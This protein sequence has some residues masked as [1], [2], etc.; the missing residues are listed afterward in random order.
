M[1]VII[2][3]RDRELLEPLIDKLTEHGFEVMA[4][5]NSSAVLSY[6]KQNSIQF[7]LADSTLLM[8]HTLAREVLNRCPL[9]RM[10]VISANPSL[11]GMIEAISNGLAD[12]FPRRPE[13]FNDIVRAVMA[14][15]E[16]II[17]WQ[18]ILL[19]D[20]PHS[21]DGDEAENGPSPNEADDEFS[22]YTGEQPD[23]GHLH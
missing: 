5:E 19:A 14:E 7:L 6:I 20:T 22:Q 17:R 12:Y 23:E 15:R 10:I 18:H 16:R 1:R 13:Y 8:G 9:A 21:G 11:L 3:G 2:V 4:M